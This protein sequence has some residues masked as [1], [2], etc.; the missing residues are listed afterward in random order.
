[1]EISEI[2]DIPP[3]SLNK[4]QKQELLNSNLNL[5]FR[6][7]FNKCTPFKKIMDATEYDYS[8]EYNF[9][10]LPFLPVR[11]FKQF[12]LKSIS[13][14]EV[15]K[16]MTSSGTSGQAV[17]RIYLD[18][19]TASMQTKTL[20]K[21]VSSFIGTKR[22]PMIIIDSESVIKD[23]NL[24]SARGAGILGFSMFGHKRLFA[25]NDR[26]ELNIEA[27]KEFIE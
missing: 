11:L 2:L 13:D 9:Q 26:M 24:F 25:L 27:L 12:E 18:R 3:Y 20:T 17:S 8:K 22:V 5:L 21:I 4:I 6:H 23:R 14:E 10:E 7:H 16:T 19:E 15:V 1:M